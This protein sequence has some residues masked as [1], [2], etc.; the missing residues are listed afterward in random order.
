MM[1]IK[2]KGQ[3]AEDKGQKGKGK[4][5]S[6]LNDFVQFIGGLYKTKN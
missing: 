3:R 1:L 4:Q 2:G 6:D 5:S